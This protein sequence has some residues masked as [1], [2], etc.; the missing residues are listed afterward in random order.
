M[1]IPVRVHSKDHLGEI[2][3]H[4]AEVYRA[5]V[6]NT[7]NTHAVAERVSAAGTARWILLRFT[8]W[9]RITCPAK[10]Y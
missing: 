1:S 3:A 10:T 2:L 7:T 8:V 6:S 5:E 9:T 4:P